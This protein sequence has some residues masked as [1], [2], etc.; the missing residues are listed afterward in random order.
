VG[1]ETKI[2]WAHHT[3]NFWVG[4]TEV[5]A[6]CDHC[7]AKAWAKRAGRPEL[8]QGDRQRTS[9][10]NWREPFKW[11]AAARKAGER[12]R[13]FVNSLSDFFDNQADE[14]WR[15]DAFNVMAQCLWL[16]FLLLTKRPQN[17]AKLAPSMARPHVAPWAPN[18]W[19]GTTVEDNEQ[20][21]RR[22]S[23]LLAIPAIVHFVSMEPLLELVEL[24]I[25]WLDPRAPS[26][27]DWVIVGGES[28]AADRRP[29]DTK[30]AEAI[31]T[32]CRRASVPVFVKQLGSHVIHEG[33]RLHLKDKKG[34][35]PAEWPEGLRVREFPKVRIAA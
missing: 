14:D 18:I 10:H 6:A 29:F 19:L 3:M 13:V 16:D 9:K 1:T 2:Q 26:A 17:I 15:C 33:V 30:W 11:N 5:S 22:L 28:G 35:D 4:C 7:Y 24:D 27:I 34:G 23:D 8:W 21:R 12:R 32:R 31:L 25:R 20:A